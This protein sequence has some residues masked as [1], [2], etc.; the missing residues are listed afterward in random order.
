MGRLTKYG[1]A[2]WR[3]DEFSNRMRDVRTTVSDRFGSRLI[4]IFVLV[5]AWLGLLGVCDCTLFRAGDVD[6]DIRVIGRHRV[7]LDP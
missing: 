5:C 2:A 6:A 1:F 7:A 3:C 4:L